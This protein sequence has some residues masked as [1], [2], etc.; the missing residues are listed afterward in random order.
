MLK[1]SI[2]E[3][4]FAKQK[5]YVPAKSFGHDCTQMLH[6]WTYINP[7]TDLGRWKVSESLPAYLNVDQTISLATESA[8]ADGAMYIYMIP[9]TF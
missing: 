1:W 5:M 7:I 2:C 4:N 9:N 3:A 8:E 6:K